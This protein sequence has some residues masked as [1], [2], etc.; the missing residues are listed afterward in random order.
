MICNSSTIEG[1]NSTNF[2]GIL[3][4]NKLTWA[5]HINCFCSKIN[6]KSFILKRLSF[7]L[8][9]KYLLII[10]YG[11]IYSHIAYG[12]EI[13]GGAAKC[14]MDRLFRIQKRVIRYIFGLNR[15]DSC[16]EIFRENGI[17]TI[18]S[19]YI[20]K[21]ILWVKTHEEK[22]LLVNE[23][24][25]INTRSNNNYFR[26]RT[27]K[28]VSDNNPYM[29]G[30]TFY[31]KLPSSIKTTEGNAFKTNLKKFLISKTLYSLEDF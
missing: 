16:K 3:V 31:N 14:H 12:I 13:W 19:L 10:Y 5:D 18:Y 26:K 20:Y 1:V 2:L 11:L 21:T 9:K 6:S 29:R 27:N 30:I 24:H 15:L 22:N 8:D 28:K 25:N 7:Y 23:I 17:F 4:D